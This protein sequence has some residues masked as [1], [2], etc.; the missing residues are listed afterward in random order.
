M[1]SLHNNRNSCCTYWHSLPRSTKQ[2]TIVLFALSM[3]MKVAYTVALYQY[4]GSDA[5]ILG[6][7]TRYLTLAQHVVSG[8]GYTYNGYIESYRPP[9]YPGYLM[10]F[11]YFGIPLIFASL[12]QSI[13]ASLLPIVSFFLAHKLLNLPQKISGLVG[14]L[15]AIEPVQNFYAVTLMPDV[16][17]ST[18]LL[19]CIYYM[20]RWLNTERVRHIVLASVAIGFA[21]YIRPAG[22]YLTLLLAV[23]A[24]A[25][26]VY[27][28]TPLR[29]RVAHLL[30][31]FVIPT[32]LM[33]P[34]CIRNYMQF[35]H[36]GFVSSLPY[37]A[38]VYAG[39]SSEA[40]ARGVPYEVVK[41]EFLSRAAANVPDPKRPLT[42]ANASY[43]LEN[44]LRSVQLYTTGY[45]TTYLMGLNTFWFSGNYHYL[46]ARY[47][48]IENPQSKPSFSMLLAGKGVSAVFQ[49]LWEMGSQPYLY[50]AILG[51][52]F[53][54]AIFLTALV[55][56]I[57]SPDRYAS[58]LFILLIIYFSITI[59]PMTIG[60]EARH[61]YAMNPLLLGFS[62]LGCIYTLRYLRNRLQKLP[63]FS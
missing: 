56:A 36:Y 16:Y 34:W 31:L 32:A 8:E 39:V 24:V 27:T 38:Y 58:M 59:L 22:L 3:A 29:Q 18:L 4:G 21:N 54:V 41:K 28:R 45:V 60:V 14:I 35:G 42:F 30:I 48:L 40:A 12:L 52:A 9:G 11:T 43:Y 55:G 19:V 15:A 50:I 25:V 44:T 62:A 26:S 33:A 49:T 57:V 46:M 23:G 20:Y 51:K 17:F 1:T 47:G 7:S 10:L 2:W 6:D 13:V 63:L 37:V 5:L 53:W 61:R